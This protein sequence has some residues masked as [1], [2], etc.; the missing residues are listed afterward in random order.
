MAGEFIRDLT[1]TQI[2]PHVR[3]RVY[4]IHLEVAPVASESVVLVDTTRYARDGVSPAASLASG[5][6]YLVPSTD[7][8]KF[9]GFGVEGVINVGDQDVTLERCMLSGIAGTSAD[10]K[11]EP[12]GYFTLPKS[13]VFPLRWQPVGNDFR[14]RVIAGAT[15][16]SALITDIKL[17]PWLVR[18]EATPGVVVFD[19]ALSG[20]KYT[21]K[22]AVP[23]AHDIGYQ[24]EIT[25]TP[26]AT[27]TVEGSNSPAEDIAA[28]TDKWFTYSKVA[29]IAVTAGVFADATAV[30]GVEIK[31]FPFS[32][33][34]LK[35]VLGSASGSAK[36]TVTTKARS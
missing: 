16:P 11:I 17:V 4:P 34:R 26:T 12:G 13:K 14:L 27:I 20:T 8:W 25:S 15:A 24:V 21:A 32:R 9:A 1:P 18:A 28:G 22:T 6:A 29:A 19:E 35:L 36:V 33:V 2:T 10:W 3:P 5:S 7:R 31:S 23:F 30:A